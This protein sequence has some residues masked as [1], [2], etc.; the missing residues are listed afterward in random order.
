MLNPAARIVG[1][2]TESYPSLARSFHEGGPVW[3]E[4]RPT[5]CDG[6]AVPFI[7]DQLYPLLQKTVDSVAVVSEEQVKDAVRVLK[8]EANLMAEGAGALALA[9]ALDTPLEDRGVSVCLVTG[10]NIPAEL[11]EELL[12][13]DPK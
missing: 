6:V 7:T 13:A 1:V 3:V 4:P 2:Q 11:R 9:A 5:I 10:G 12:G 8:Q